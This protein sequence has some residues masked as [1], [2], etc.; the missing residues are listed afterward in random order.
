[1]RGNGFR[2]ND[3][4]ALSSMDLGFRDGDVASSHFG[5]ENLLESLLTRNFLDTLEVLSIS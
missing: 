4:R 1:M 2:S 5:G 3:H